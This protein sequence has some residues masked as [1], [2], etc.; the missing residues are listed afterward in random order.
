MTTADQP[1]AEGRTLLQGRTIDGIVFVCGA[2]VM[3]LEMIGSRILAPHL[4]TAIV[5]WTGLIGVVLGALSLGYFLGGRWADAH[6]DPAKLSLILFLAG[7][8]VVATWLVQTPFLLRLQTATLPLEV[9]ATL[10]ALVLFGPAS[11]LLG[12]VTPYAVRLSLADLGRSGRTVGR[13]YALSTLGS[14][15]GT[16]LAGFVLLALFGSTLILLGLALILIALS[17]L[18]AAGNWRQSMRLLVAALISLGMVLSMASQRADEQRG[19]VDLDTPYNRIRISS[20]IER[21]S[22]RPVRFMRTGPRWFQSA[23]YPDA[24]HELAVPYTRFFRLHRHFKPGARSFLVIGGGGYTSPRDILR[25]HPEAHV[26]VVEIDPAF[27]D[28]AQRYFF[29]TPSPQLVVHHEDARLFLNRPQETFEV[30]ITDAFSSGYTIPF[31]MTTVE[32]VRQMARRLTDDGVLLVN[33]LSAFEGPR[34]RFFRAYLATIE[35]VFP[36]VLTFAVFDPE[37]RQRVQN[38]VIVALKNSAAA[39]LESDDPEIGAYLS[40]LWRHPVARDL[41][42]LTDDF[43]PVD[44]Y[45]LGMD[46]EAIRT[47]SGDG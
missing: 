25:K 23:I 44:H 16:F 20:G 29:L 14:I 24:P 11:V 15:A 45:S 2:V 42:I 4:G 17:M 34:G 12:M 41:P 7:I 37:N 1:R 47:R 38:I 19:E 39:I 43:A 32:A 27:T 26:N 3:A 30:I 40:Y 28:L 5:V 36:Q 46:D 35:A 33:I 31:Q 13:L 6:P 22:N 18:L 21:G 10:A 8:A 9:K